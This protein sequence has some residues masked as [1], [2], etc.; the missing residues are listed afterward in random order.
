MIIKFYKSEAEKNRL[1]KSSFLKSEKELNGNLIEDTSLLTP[2]I[3][4]ESAENMKAYNYCY[5]QLFGRYYHI[6][7]VVALEHNFYHIKMEVDV[8]HTYKEEI[9]NLSGVI[10]RT[11]DSRSKTNYLPDGAIWCYADSMFRSINFSNAPGYSNFSSTS[12]GGEEYHES[13]ILSIVG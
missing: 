1:D 5:I 3:T 8:L 11:S 12:Q 7:D 2:E 6:T 9:R 13:Y 4:I 10:A